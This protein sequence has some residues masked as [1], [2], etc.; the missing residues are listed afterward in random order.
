MFPLRYFNP[1]Y[2]ASRYWPKVGGIPIVITPDCFNLSSGVIND[3]P[4]INT[5]KITAYNLS[6]G[7]IEPYQ[8]NAGKITEFNVNEGGLCCGS[9]R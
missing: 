3:D 2:W 4:N 1:R 5:G 7:K 6:A 8:N 9:T